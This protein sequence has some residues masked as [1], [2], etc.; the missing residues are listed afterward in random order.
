[1]LMFFLQSKKSKSKSCCDGKSAGPIVLFLSEKHR[2][3][4]E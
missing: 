2:E 4:E 1:M 3:E